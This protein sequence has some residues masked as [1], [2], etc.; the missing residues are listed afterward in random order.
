[1]LLYLLRGATVA[2]YC[3]EHQPTELYRHFTRTGSAPSRFVLEISAAWHC[4]LPE[5]IEPLLKFQKPSWS[6]SMRLALIG[7][8]ILKS[9]LLRESDA[10]N[11]PRK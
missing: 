6:R 3:Q 1:V 7:T 11:L 4:C 10:Q 2:N 8:V 5:R 9:S